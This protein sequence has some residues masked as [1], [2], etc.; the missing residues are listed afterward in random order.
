MNSNMTALWYSPSDCAA[1]ECDWRTERL[2]WTLS[3]TRACPP[4]NA[5]SRP[6]RE[7]SRSCRPRH[8]PWR[9]PDSSRL[10]RRENGECGSEWVCVLD[11]KQLKLRQMLPKY[12]E[13]ILITQHAWTERD[14]KAARPQLLQIARQV[15]CAWVCVGL[16]SFWAIFV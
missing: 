9:S 2:L 12:L 15:R 4:T 7:C 5:L 10:Q 11:A 8:S 16:W 13:G 3:S 1:A 6:D 14:Y